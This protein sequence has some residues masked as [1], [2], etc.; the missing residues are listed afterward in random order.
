MSGDDT[1]LR[2]TLRS[3]LR[4]RAALGRRDRAAIHAVI[5][6]ALVCHVA[7][8][9]KAEPVVLPTIAWRVDDWL[10]LHGAASSRLLAEVREAEAV[11]VSITLV[12]MAS[13]SR[14]RRCDA[15]CTTAWWC[16]LDAARQSSRRPPRS[17]RC[18]RWST[19]SPRE[20][21]CM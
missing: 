10:Y 16:Y 2:V 7:F 19:S 14:G 8:V 20:G 9:E 4:R 15:L 11:C 12:E 6:E 13:C 5:D 18:S 1:R 21:R 3:T 17:Q